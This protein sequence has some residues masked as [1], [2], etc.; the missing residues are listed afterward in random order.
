MPAV[1]AFGHLVGDDTAADGFLKP[2]QATQFG[3]RSADGAD[4]VHRIVRGVLYGESDEER[5]LRIGGNGG[6]SCAGSSGQRALASRAPL[7][8]AAGFDVPRCVTIAAAQSQRLAAFREPLGK[9]R[10]T[11]GFKPGDELFS[12]SFE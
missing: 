11:F 9:V 12:G 4:Q 5:P 1:F 2:A 10:S 7:E 3:V 6:V 8:I